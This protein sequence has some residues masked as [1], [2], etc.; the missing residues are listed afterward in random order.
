M[1]GSRGCFGCCLK[2]KP[3]TAVDAP[4]K[5]SEIHDRK[6]KNPSKS[7]NF[8]ST[9]TLDMDNSAVQ[10]QGSIS[11]ISTS[12]QTIDP[13]AGN[14]GT[15]SEFVNHGLILWNQTRQRW[16]G[17]KRSENQTQQVQPKLNW[18]A[19]YDNLLGS[20]KPFP[21]PIPLSE[22]VDFLVDTWEQEGL[23]D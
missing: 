3:T 13:Q 22:M 15:P 18:N 1:H 14:P 11:S 8:W 16:I 12:N 9:S 10:S 19:T 5:G 20:D 6:L 4:S 17:N 21:H 7:E 2:P 23:Y